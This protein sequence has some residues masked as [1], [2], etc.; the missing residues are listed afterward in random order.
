MNRPA[1]SL[2]P[3]LLAM[4]FVGGIYSPA[5]AQSTATPA[6]TN[7]THETAVAHPWSSLDAAQQDILAP[8]QKTWDTLS[9]RR[10][11]HMLRRAERWVTLPAEKREKIRQ[12]IAHWQQMTP[13]ERQ[14]ARDNRRKFDEL[15][16]AQR[17]R[18][19]ATYEHF[20]QLPAA[21][22]DQLM[23]QWHALSPQ[24]RLQWSE[25]H[26]HG[27]AP[28]AESSVAAPSSVSAGEPAQP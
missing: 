24:Q 2:V 26:Q 19:H 28:A 7:N 11:T 6:A 14:Q 15:T 25:H 23:H 8:L 9:P 3:A 4:L 18:L 20:Q 21:Q 10:Q 16:P 27:T 12:H 5:Y 22:R 1:L 13:Q 17:E